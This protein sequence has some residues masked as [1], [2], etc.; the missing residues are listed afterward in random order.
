MKPK[1]WEAMK[2]MVTNFTQADM[3]ATKEEA[4]EKLNQDPD[5]H[6]FSIVVTELPTKKTDMVYQIRVI[7]D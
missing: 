5:T 7:D 2:F 3:Y 6:I 1:Q 4:I